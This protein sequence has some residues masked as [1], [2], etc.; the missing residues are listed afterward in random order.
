MATNSLI[1]PSSENAF[2]PE[3]YLTEYRIPGWYFFVQLLSGLY[4]KKSIIIGIILPLY[5]MQHF[6]LSKIFN[7]QLFGYNASGQLFVCLLILSCL[8]STKLLESLQPCL[9][10]FI[11]YFFQYLAV[12]MYPLF[13]GLQKHTFYSFEIVPQALRLW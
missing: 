1:F 4:N 7:F 5:V 10:Q 2:I 8:G 9:C 11:L 6:S 3:R 13:L 12:P